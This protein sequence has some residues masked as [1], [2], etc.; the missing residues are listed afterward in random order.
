MAKQAEIEQKK[1]EREVVLQK[2]QNDRAVAMQAVE[3]LNASS[4]QITSLL[5]ARQ[6]ERAA[7]R[8]AAEAA[9]AAAAQQAAP[10]ILGYKGLVNLAGLLVVKLLH[11]MAIV[12]IQ[13]GVL[14]FTIRA[15]ILVLM[16]VHLF[17]LR[18]AVLLFGLDGWVVMV[19]P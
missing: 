14:Q 9:A 16:R 17:M 19:M 4:A 13:F 1:Q 7:A 8:A 11:H 18:M 6:A 10:S 15:S 5:K 12:H 3:E 2:A